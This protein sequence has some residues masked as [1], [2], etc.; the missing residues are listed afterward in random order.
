MRAQ[1]VDGGKAHHALGHLRLD[2]PVGV[3]RIGHAVDDTRLEYGDRRLLLARGGGMTLRRGNGRILS[4]AWGGEGARAPP[5]QFSRP[6]PVRPWPGGLRKSAGCDSLGSSAGGAAGGLGRSSGVN[7]SGVKASLVRVSARSRSFREVEE[8]NRLRRLG[9]APPGAGGA[10]GGPSLR[11]REAASSCQG[12][13]AE[14]AGVAGSPPGLSIA[15]WSRVKGTAVGGDCRHAR[16]RRRNCRLQGR[17][18]IR[19][20][21]QGTTEPLRNRPSAPAPPSTGRSG[22]CRRRR[23]PR[24]TG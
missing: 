24:R 17:F 7:K 10:P 18:R 22:S 13:G 11:V 23:R 3:E 8:N 15:G 9:A 19:M 12:G 21:R 5:R 4:F 16:G 20:G 2:R 14:A 1:F 6:R